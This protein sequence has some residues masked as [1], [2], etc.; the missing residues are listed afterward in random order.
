MKPYKYWKKVRMNFSVTC[1]QGRLLIVIQNPDAI[2]VKTNT[3]DY[4]KF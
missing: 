2:R 4:I 3:F 1:I